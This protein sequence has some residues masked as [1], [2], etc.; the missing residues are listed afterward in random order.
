MREDN[1]AIVVG[2]TFCFVGVTEVEMIFDVE[3]IAA[4]TAT[5]GAEVEVVLQLMQ[6]LSLRLKLKGF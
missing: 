6:L 1:A 4:G 5:F 3:E 2:V